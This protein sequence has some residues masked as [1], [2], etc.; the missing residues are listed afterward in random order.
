M[1]DLVPFAGT[2]WQMANRN[3]KLQFAG[4]PLKLY[5]PK[6]YA[7]AVAPAAVGGDHQTF[8]LGMAFPAHGPPPSAHGI[9]GEGSGIVIRPNT[10]PPSCC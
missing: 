3:W 8:G 9:D 2:G 5:L 10:D 1:L 4:E 6:P 7:V